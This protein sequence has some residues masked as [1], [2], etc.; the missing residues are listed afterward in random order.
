[1]PNQPLDPAF[2]SA[3]TRVPPPVLPPG[4]PDKP[5]PHMP[6]LGV[7]PVF[8][9]NLSKPPT[10]TPGP[11]P[12]VFPSLPPL[13]VPPPPVNIRP[14]PL[15][16][17]AGHPPHIAAGSNAAPVA[18]YR[19]TFP[20]PPVASV[21]PVDPSTS[22]AASDIAKK[23]ALDDDPFAPSA[24][25]LK[26]MK[27]GG[28]F[29]V[30]AGLEEE[31]E[32]FLARRNR[33]I[34]PELPLSR[35]GGWDRH[36]G[37]DRDWNRGRRDN[38]GWRPDRNRGDRMPRDNFRG[39]RDN[40]DRDNR[41]RERDRDRD[42]WGRD[43]RD[44][45]DRPRDR[46]GRDRSRSPLR[47]R[48]LG[49]RSQQSNNNDN[50]ENFGGDATS[51]SNREL[52]EEVA[53][54][55]VADH[56]QQSSEASAADASTA[57]YLNEARED[58]NAASEPPQE[59]NFEL[60]KFN[61]NESYDESNTSEPAR[62]N[63]AAFGENS[64]HSGDD[65]SNDRKSFG[66]PEDSRSNDEPLSLVTHSKGSFGEA[67]PDAMEHNAAGFERNGTGD[68]DTREATVKS[69]ALRADTALDVCDESN[70]TC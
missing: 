3:Q 14:P 11:V 40:R 45:P 12:P 30:P 65:Y 1:M 60:R 58:S 44:S 9:P 41:S 25:E 54:V 59:T 43:R 51:E 52:A 8:P 16:A 70:E 42:R 7:P 2:L 66:V 5:P 47:D 35:G 6:P 24:Y 15:S 23:V 61:S 29:A 26:A 56:S 4:L 17:W 38:D 10:S 18:A 37:G 31:H 69:D 39:G 21:P 13:N 62:E 46:F 27:A 68:N 57:S 55:Y 63:V 64:A 50:N 67:K 49:E 53:N 34:E 32:R 48:Q 28:R 20:P 36:S 19:P 33:V 22:F